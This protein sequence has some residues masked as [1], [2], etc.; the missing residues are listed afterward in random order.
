MPNPE[1]R[2]PPKRA[3]LGYPLIEKLIE[4]EDFSKIQ[5]SFSTCYEALERMLKKKVGGL[6]KQGQIRQ[7][8]KAYDL[9][10]DLLR[11]LLKTKYEMVKKDPKQGVVQKK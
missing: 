9:T 7:A 2:P 6:K 11:L 8:I 5:S 4:T 1:Q 10:I 3:L